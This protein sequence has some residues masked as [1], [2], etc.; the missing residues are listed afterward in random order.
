M[1]LQEAVKQALAST[2][3]LEEQAKEVEESLMGVKEDEKR[4]EEENAKI[5]GELE[6]KNAQV[7]SVIKADR[8]RISDLQSEL[9]S[10]SNRV[11]KLTTKRDK[12]EKDT[13]SDLDTQ[14]IQLR[15]E[16]EETERERE[17][18]LNPFPFGGVAPTTGHTS[19]D[20]LVVH[21]LASL[22]SSGGVRLPNVRQNNGRGSGNFGMPYSQGQMNGAQLSSGQVN[23]SQLNL[24][25]LNSSQSNPTPAATG[26]INPSATPFYPSQERHEPLNRMPLSLSGVRPVVMND[27]RPFENVIP[28]PVG[29]GTSGP[30]VSGESGVNP[31]STS[32]AGTF[33]LRTRLGRSS[34]GSQ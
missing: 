21:G 32:S 22:R 25:Q 13:I 4:A 11:D 18:Y 31:T 29:T 9:S 34:R 12:L 26:Q 15:K 20:P 19:D 27:F 24:P 33:G 23:L 1:A 16:I 28:G 2:G 8:K 3:T 10:L 5:K 7:D 6:E 17:N 30:G 14:L